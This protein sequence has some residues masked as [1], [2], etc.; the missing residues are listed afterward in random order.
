MNELYE[1]TEQRER[2]KT[3]H[4]KRDLLIAEAARLER[5]V[6]LLKNEHFQQYLQLRWNRDQELLAATGDDPFAAG[7]CVGRADVIME[8]RADLAATQDKLQKVGEKI[9]KLNPRNP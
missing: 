3:R 9:E 2:N 1:L 5:L 8:I 6:N 7:R 4:V